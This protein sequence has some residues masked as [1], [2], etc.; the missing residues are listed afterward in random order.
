[1][2]RHSLVGILLAVGYTILSRYVLHSKTLI[3]TS[4]LGFLFGWFLYDVIRLMIRRRRIKICTRPFPHICRV[5][6]PCNGL[7]ND[8]PDDVDELKS[9]AWREAD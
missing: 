7:P 4:F 1:M 9:D 6:G 5:N 3:I 2:L 8:S